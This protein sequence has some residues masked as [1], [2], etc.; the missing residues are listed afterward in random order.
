MTH[1]DIRDIKILK[2]GTAEQGGWL[3]FSPTNN[4]YSVIIP[5]YY[6][7]LLFR[8]II[9]RTFQNSLC[10]VTSLVVH[11]CVTC[12]SNQPQYLVY[13]DR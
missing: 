10:S 11:C 2:S 9:P 5:R 4:N 13:Y 8:V 6:S 12:I 1:F 7:A 3:G